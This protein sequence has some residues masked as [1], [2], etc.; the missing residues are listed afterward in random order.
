MLIANY[1]RYVI[2]LNRDPAGKPLYGDRN[3]TELCPLTTF[4]NEPIYLQ[5]LEPDAIEI[6][7]RTERYWR[8][9]HRK[10]QEELCR[11]QQKFGAAILFDAHSIRSLV[12]RFHEG[13]IPDLNLGTANGRST[14]DAPAK[15]A[16][17]ILST[18]GLDLALNGVFAGGFIT[19]H[20]GVPRNNIHALQLELT[21]RN[22]MDEESHEYTPQR[23]NRLQSTLR[24]LLTRLIAWAEQKQ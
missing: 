8:P 6:A 20:Y 17:E 9:Y 19:R 16:Y 12:P 7:E 3:N 11:I 21:W 22:Y 23:A 14:D 18:S 2:D 13:P 24:E 15:I 1:S 5:G 10:L 4:D